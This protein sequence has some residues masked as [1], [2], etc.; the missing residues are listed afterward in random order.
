MHGYFKYVLTMMSLENLL[1]AIIYY[2]YLYYSEI[3]LAESI[4]KSSIIFRKI[5]FLLK[6]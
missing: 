4:E 5:K 6:E 3:S 2:L 1:R